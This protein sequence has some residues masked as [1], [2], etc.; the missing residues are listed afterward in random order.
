MEKIRHDFISRQLAGSHQRDHTL[1]CERT[2]IFV[3]LLVFDERAQA[4]EVS[5]RDRRQN[6][7]QILSHNVAGQVEWKLTGPGKDSHQQRIRTCFSEQRQQIHGVDV[8]HTSVIHQPWFRIRV[9]IFENR[10]E[11]GNHFLSPRDD[12][13]NQVSGKRTT[14]PVQTVKKLLDVHDDCQ[15]N[16]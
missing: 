9:H 13:R 16:I 5:A 4:A 14:V 7:A 15:S 2:D 11:T 6:P 12:F 3:R 8:D 10:K 1:H